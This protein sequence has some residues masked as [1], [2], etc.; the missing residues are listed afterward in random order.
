MIRAA[1]LADTDK[2][3]FIIALK[4]NLPAYADIEKMSRP[5]FFLSSWVPQKE[6][7]ALPQTKLF[8]THCGSNSIMESLYFGVPMLGFG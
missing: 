2:V 1:K 3:G 5:N 6:I 7:L 4:K 8:L